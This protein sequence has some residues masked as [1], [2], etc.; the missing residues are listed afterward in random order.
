MRIGILGGTFDPIHYGHIRPAMEVKH[1]LALDKILLMPNH[2]PPHKQQ[3]NLTTAQRLKM[4]AD[5]CS[6]LDGFELCDIEAKRDTPSYTVIT[7][8]QLKALHPK[9]ELFFIMGMDS[10]IQ[11]Q[12]WHE[13]QRLF[14][15]AHLVVCQRPGWQLDAEHPMQQ[16]LTARS[17][18]QA[19][20]EHAAN[21]AHRNDGQI[22]PVTIT[23]QDISSTHIREQLA[24]GEIPADLLMPVTLD[25]I[26]NQ[27]LYLP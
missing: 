20:T 4:V 3:P 26:Q 18:A 11:L 15:F 17:Q 25:Y 12:S 10:F 19:L 16:I 6:Q 1:A 21:P 24:K 5:V 27:R 22:I 8:E 9:D 23:P 14:D 13:W 7:L 2:I